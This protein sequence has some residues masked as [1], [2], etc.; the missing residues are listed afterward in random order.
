VRAADPS[1]NDSAP[2]ASMV[3]RTIRHAAAC[4]PRAGDL[5]N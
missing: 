2:I 5:T 4:R 1:V 3:R